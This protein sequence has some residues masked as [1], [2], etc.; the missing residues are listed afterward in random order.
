M[1]AIGQSAEA[2]RRNA[3]EAQGNDQEHSAQDSQL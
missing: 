3:E 2:E 1:D